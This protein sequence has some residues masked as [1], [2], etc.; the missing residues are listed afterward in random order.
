MAA[1]WAVALGFGAWAAPG[2]AASGNPEN[3]DPRDEAAT[4]AIGAAL[5]YLSNGSNEDPERANAAL[6][7]DASPEVTTSDLDDIRQTHADDL[8][9]ITRVDLDAGDAVPTTD[10]IGVGITVFYIYDGKQQFE[11]FVVTVQED[12][13]TFCVSDAVLAA[14]E[15]EPSSDDATGEAVDP[16]A[17]ATD[18]LRTIVVEREPATAADFQCGSYTGVTPQDLDTAITEW[19]VSNGETTAFLNG[20]EPAET[21]GTSITNIEVEV[22]LEG[23]L[24]NETFVFVVAV[25]GDCVA[26]LAGGEGLI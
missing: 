4:D 3:V 22:S 23:D 9:G 14:V 10:G 13:G 16:Q 2:I 24:N 18:F 1:L 20:A 7:E 8:G 25:Q 5:R 15:E 21:S 17:L 12:D 26:S 6:C 11:D 19:A